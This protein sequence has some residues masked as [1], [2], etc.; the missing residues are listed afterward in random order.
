MSPVGRRPVLGVLCGLVVCVRGGAAPPLAQLQVLSPALRA[1]R[2]AAARSQRADR[3]VDAVAELSSSAHRLD[4]TTTA[5]ANGIYKARLAATESTEGL[6]SATVTTDRMLVQC[7]SASEVASE[8]LQLLARSAGAVTALSLAGEADLPRAILVANAAVSARVH[9]EEELRVRSE[10]LDRTITECSDQANRSDSRADGAREAFAQLVDDAAAMSTSMS[11]L[12]KAAQEATDARNAAKA[13]AAAL[14]RPFIAGFEID[15]GQ[16]ARALN[17]AMPGRAAAVEREAMAALRNAGTSLVDSWATLGRTTDA[18][19]YARLGAAEPGSV[20]RG[21]NCN[22]L[23]VDLDALSRRAP[24]ARAAVEDWLPRNLAAIELLRAAL[25]TA[26]EARRQSID[27]VQRLQQTVGNDVGRA[28][29]ALRSVEGALTALSDGAREEQLAARNAWD[30]ARQRAGLPS[31]LRP[32]P[33]PMAAPAAA[34]PAPP[35]AAPY[36]APQVRSHAYVSINNLGQEPDQF[37]AYTYLL[38]PSAHVLGRPEARRRMI[39]VV[40]TLQDRA[41][42][43][44]LVPS[45]AKPQVN[46]FCI[47][48]RRSATASASSVVDA[49]SGDLGQQVLLRA[50]HGITLRPELRNRLNDSSG[51]FLL[52]LPRRAHQTEFERSLLLADLAPYDEEA[53][54]DLVI[55]YMRGLVDAFPR[56]QELW[57]PPTAHR[58]AL[59]L[60]SWASAPARILTSVVAP[61][62]AGTPQR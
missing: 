1:E 60:I 32:P 10:T 54:A 4:T 43:A 30:E 24:Q 49:Y 22:D 47:P 12:S 26:S 42:D 38:V 37:G 16:R 61:A 11:N 14:P 52:T 28:R 6:R 33:P 41:T 15:P 7:R 27:L 56:E 55:A 58:I 8:L 13:P 9:R 34:A 20:C 44:A 62:T 17:D 3:W 50:R 19:L 29:Q 25:G 46:L 51:P 2:A 40:L 21:Q 57:R 5:V 35:P 36:P 45:S 39:R 31:V 53:I 23:A 18:A 59:T 48:S